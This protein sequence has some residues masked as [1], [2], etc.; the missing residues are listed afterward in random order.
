VPGSVFDHPAWAGARGVVTVLRDASPVAAPGGATLLPCPLTEK[1]GSK[2]PTEAIPR[3][4]SGASG[5]AHGGGP[6]RVGV[7][8][9]TLQGVGVDSENEF[10]IPLD[11][12][13][14]AGVDYLAIGHWH[15]TF[16][17]S[18][19]ARVA[20]SGSHETTKFGERDSG[21]AL[22]VEIAARGLAPRI[23]KVRTGSL[24]WIE[25]KRDLASAAD[26]EALRR[27]VE[28]IPSPETTLV[29]LVLAGALGADA[30]AETA[31]L[32]EIL[33]ARF[34]FGRVERDA[35][36][37]AP[38][39]ASWIDA[40]PPGPV[41]AA[42]RRLAEAPESDAVAR[43]ALVRLFSLSRSAGAGAS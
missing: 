2:D 22:L 23:E 18:V 5:G 42:A 26:V 15:S 27:E 8:H 13:E 20:Y 43:E 29:R 31:R 37:L 24:A 41:Q 28:A 10:P 16:S 21:N 7:A 40:L 3:P 36:V 32:D 6:I 14:R 11:A 19:G 1:T 12:A 17:P 4:D 38:G 35:I 9:G 30:I 39:D 33:A 25:R 34:L